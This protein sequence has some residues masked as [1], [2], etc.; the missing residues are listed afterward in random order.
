MVSTASTNRPRRRYLYFRYIIS[1][2]ND[3]RFNTVTVTQKMESRRFWPSGGEYLQRSTM[4]TL[5]RC[6]SG[7]EI[8]EDLIQ[9]KAF[10][11]DPK[12]AGDEEEHAMSASS[13]LRCEVETTRAATMASIAAA[14][15]EGSMN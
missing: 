1:Y 15:A 3:K 4:V 12:P 14:G 7:C 9:G 5:A 8:P 13:R 2:L 6:I 10:D 11:G